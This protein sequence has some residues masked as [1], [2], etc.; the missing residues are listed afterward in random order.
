MCDIF[1][2]NYF[3]TIKLFIQH[4]QKNSIFIIKTPCYETLSPS[5]CSKKL[6]LQHGNA[7]S[8]RRRA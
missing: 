5:A 6:A 7:L 4:K 1:N 2:N 8:R 3:H